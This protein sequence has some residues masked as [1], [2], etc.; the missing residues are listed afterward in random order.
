ML[1]SGSNMSGL[2]VLECFKRVFDKY[3]HRWDDQDDTI[4]HRSVRL[5]FQVVLK[6][7]LFFFKGLGHALRS[8]LI[9]RYHSVKRLNPQKLGYLIGSLTPRVRSRLSLFLYRIWSNIVIRYR[10]TVKVS[11]Y[12]FTVLSRQKNGPLVDWRQPGWRTN[13]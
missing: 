2:E 12:L 8:L 10:N 1:S 6:F 5:C 9:R 3:D 13:N 11:I 4:L 7:L